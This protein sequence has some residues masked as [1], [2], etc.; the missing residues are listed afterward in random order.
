MMISEEAR[1]EIDTKIKEYTELINKAQD[2][3]TFFTIY[4]TFGYILSNISNKYNDSEVGRYMQ[5]K[6]DM[7]FAPVSNITS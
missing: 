4:D 7:L 6:L 5:L 3:N 1:T 2:K